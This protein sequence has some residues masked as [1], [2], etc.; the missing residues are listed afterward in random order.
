MTVNPGGSGKPH[1]LGHRLRLKERFRKSGRKALADHELIELLL[2]YAVPR[3]DTK[4]IAKRLLERFGSFQAA[5]DAPQE[6][7]E[8]T[9]G[10]GD[11]AST[12]VSL[13]RAC[14]N[15]YLEPSGDNRTVIT[16]PEDVADYVRAEIGGSA[17]EQF[18]LICLNAAGRIIHTRTMAE[19]TV[20]AAHVYP[21]EVLKAA[22]NCNATALILVHNHPSG[23]LAASEQ[24]LRLTRSLTEIC[25]QV[26][27]SLHDHLIV[28]RSGAYSIRLQAALPRR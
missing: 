25:S 27:I 16:G 14:M 13:F 22:M 12:L 23:T 1:Y 24:D 5:L 20:D 3:K 18:L 11:H 15:R 2:A 8:E 9:N 10:I 6:S 7:L 19:G 21:R 28:T 26:G 17:R 4:P